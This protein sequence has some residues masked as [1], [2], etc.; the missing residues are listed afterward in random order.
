MRIEPRSA[1][2]GAPYNG[3]RA[4]SPINTK[5][6]KMHPYQSVASVFHYPTASGGII[7][8]ERDDRMQLALR[9]KRPDS[10]NPISRHLP[11]LKE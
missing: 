4:G 11:G 3:E 7:M 1:E 8:R 10:C 5:Q 6:F 2:V 9:R